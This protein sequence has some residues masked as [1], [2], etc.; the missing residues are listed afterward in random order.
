MSTVPFLLWRPAGWLLVLFP[1]D[2]EI[3]IEQLEYYLGHTA[4]HLLEGLDEQ[5]PLS[6]KNLC[7][8]HKSSQGLR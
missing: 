1:S 8:S 4:Q 2:E 3:I 5:E 6:T 7:R